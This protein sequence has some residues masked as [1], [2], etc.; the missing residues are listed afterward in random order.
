[1][2]DAKKIKEELIEQVRA[3]RFCPIIADILIDG[4]L[5]FHFGFKYCLWTKY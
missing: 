3:L 2:D 4:M 1:M 5:D